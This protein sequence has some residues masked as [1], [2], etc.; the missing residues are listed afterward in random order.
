MR[1]PQIIVGNLL[2]L[3]LIAACHPDNTPPG[4]R[5]EEI[6]AHERQGLDALK[7]GHLDVFAHLTADEAVFIDPHGVA[8]KAEVLKNLAG[9]RLEDYSI[10]NAKLV[11]VSATAGLL[12]YKIYEKGNSH[13]REFSAKAF[14]SALWVKRQGEWVCAFSQETPTK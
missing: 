6:V 12:T 2:A 10:E 14:I 9:F 5:L 3:L 4:P 7:T 1:I 11:P 8:N 13:G